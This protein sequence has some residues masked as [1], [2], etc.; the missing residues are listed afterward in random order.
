VLDEDPPDLTDDGGMVLSQMAGRHERLGLHAVE[1]RALVRDQAVA[2]AG[3]GRV[4]P[5]GDDGMGAD[6]RREAEPF[7][8]GE[9]R[10]SPL[11]FVDSRGQALAAAFGEEVRTVAGEKSLV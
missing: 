3:P 4:V 7:Q 8:T 2:S 11:Q 1:M 9:D 5:F 10:R 6:R